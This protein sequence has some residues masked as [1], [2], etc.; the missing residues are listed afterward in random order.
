MF[1]AGNFFGKAGRVAGQLLSLSS[2]ES[3]V[4]DQTKPLLWFPKFIWQSM[5]CQGR[6]LLFTYTTL[7][8]LENKS[9]RK[10][11]HRMMLDSINV[12]IVFQDSFATLW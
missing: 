9:F 2:G 8:R 7:Y 3:G 5:A 1:G 11:V 4:G 12:D 10:R 6:P